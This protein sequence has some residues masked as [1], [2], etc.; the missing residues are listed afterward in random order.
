MGQNQRVAV[1]VED[2]DLVAGSYDSDELG[3]RALS[4]WDVTEGR[5]REYGIDL[6]VSD[7]QG[8]GVTVTQVDQI[9]QPRLPGK[10]IGNLQQRLARIQADCHTVRPDTSGQVTEDDAATATHL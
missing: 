9:G 3:H 5:N 6:T 4:V 2:T 8:A 10:L 7:W 1:D